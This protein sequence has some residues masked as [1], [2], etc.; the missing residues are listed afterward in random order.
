MAQPTKPKFDPEREITW[1]VQVDEQIN[2]ASEVDRSARMQ[3]VQWHNRADKLREMD[4]ERT[5]ESTLPPSNDLLTAAKILDAL[6]DAL[7]PTAAFSWKQEE[8]VATAERVRSF[9]TLGMVDD[10]LVEVAN[11]LVGKYS[12]VSKARGTAKVHADRPAKVLV[13]A[14]N[15]DVITEQTGNSDNSPGN[16]RNTIINWLKSNNI[17]LTD[18]QKSEVGKQVR[19]CL[20]DKVP[21][22][23]IGDFATITHKV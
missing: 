6:S 23:Q 18:E 1:L 13:T 4:G 16:V 17:E 5:G 2:T 12:A 22:V 15:G 21:T 10:E 7:N 9:L 8:L 11:E 14:T 19:S 3:S 20:V